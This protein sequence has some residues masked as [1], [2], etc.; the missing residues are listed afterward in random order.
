MG[1]TLKD[2]EFWAAERGMTLEEYEQF[3]EDAEAQYFE[4][5]VEDPD[6][7]VAPDPDVASYLD[8]D[9]L[10]QEATPEQMEEI[11]GSVLDDL[12]LELERED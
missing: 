1:L 10:G 11:D 3:L 7:A 8:L 5:M 12:I 2:K 9:I 6:G 4:A